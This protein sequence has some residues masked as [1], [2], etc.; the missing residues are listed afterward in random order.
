MF[1]L[2]SDCFCC[3]GSAS[4]HKCVSG[5]LHSLILFIS[6]FLLFFWCSFC[7]RDFFNELCFKKHKSIWLLP[8]NVCMNLRVVE[9]II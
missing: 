9:G 6:V 4:Y 1:P 2:F 8:W 7:N 3:C 5:M